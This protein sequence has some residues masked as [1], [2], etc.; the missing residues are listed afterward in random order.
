MSLLNKIKAILRPRRTTANTQDI[1]VVPTEDIVTKVEPLDEGFYKSPFKDAEQSFKTPKKVTWQPGISDSPRTP[2]ISKLPRNVFQTP[3]P[4]TPEAFNPLSDKE[5]KILYNRAKQGKHSGLVT[6]D[7]VK[8]YAKRKAGGIFQ[9]IKNYAKLEDTEAGY[10]E[11]SRIFQFKPGKPLDDISTGSIKD[12]FSRELL[13]PFEE[14][15]NKYRQFLLDWIKDKYLVSLDKDEILKDIKEQ[16][17]VYII[18]SESYAPEFKYL[19]SFLNISQ[20]KGI[21]SKELNK[22]IAKANKRLIKEIDSRV[23]KQE[24]LI[25]KP[26]ISS[27]HDSK[28]KNKEIPEKILNYIIESGIKELRNL[29]KDAT[30]NAIKLPRGFLREIIEELAKRP[31]RIRVL[32]DVIHQVMQKGITAKELKRAIGNP[33]FFDVGIVKQIINSQHTEATLSII[34]SD[35]DKKEVKEI[36]KYIKNKVISS[37]DK[38]GKSF[39]AQNI[40]NVLPFEMKKE[41]WRNLD[42]SIKSV[43]ST[44]SVDE[45]LEKKTSKNYLLEILM[46]DVLIKSEEKLSLLKKHK[47]IEK[48]ISEG[49]P[50]HFNIIL[51]N[52]DD[53]E[54]YKLISGIVLK[55]LA[56]LKDPDLVSQISVIISDRSKSFPDKYKKELKKSFNIEQEESEEFESLDIESDISSINSLILSE[57]EGLLTSKEQLSRKAELA[58][59]WKNVE[60]L[61]EKVKQD[62]KKTEELLSKD[63]YDPKSVI[64][65][66]KI[67]ELQK[68]R[69]RNSELL[70]EAREILYKS[71][72]Q[73][74]ISISSSTSSQATLG[75]FSDYGSD[76]NPTSTTIVDAE[77]K[78]EEE[79]E[80]LKAENKEF[81]SGKSEEEVGKLRNEILSSRFSR[82]QV[83]RKTEEPKAEKKEF[84]SEKPKELIEEAVEEQKFLEGL[85]KELEE[86]R[87]ARKSFGLGSIKMRPEVDRDET[88][89]VDSGFDTPTFG[90]EPST[91]CFKPI[92]PINEQ[93]AIKAAEK[94]ASKR[95]Q[96]DVSTTLAEVD[97]FEYNKDGIVTS[98]TTW[99]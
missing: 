93:L 36:Y 23:E 85:K 86:W 11:L 4:Q 66:D 42:D 1:P 27:E 84:L 54:A 25:S 76:F 26:M 45:V 96:E 82:R 68:T 8:G 16:G 63:K 58:D 13:G 77:K 48:C 38:D 18:I 46:K 80:E 33:N 14:G 70:Y 41:V 99:V 61:A 53:K 88:R 83:A 55:E 34:K 62:E 71:D 37:I 44:A 24:E 50:E 29:S 35:L 43:D 74:A 22:A 72:E 91:P 40:Y 64:I 3:I 89:S 90:E 51:N 28:S 75:G 30:L 21:S 73:D 6:R 12:L 19:E 57:E 97:I 10:K 78:L 31:E 47:I 87:K 2:Q 9:I 49:S 79:I 69:Q 52:L 7:A 39:F 17:P 32:G 81:F 5:E 98:R 92:K 67:A 60:I 95:N 56:E 15:T 20:E 94:D 59:I 65:T